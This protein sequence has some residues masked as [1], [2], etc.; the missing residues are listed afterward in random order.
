[1]S[2]EARNDEIE[3]LQKLENFVKFIDNDDPTIIDQFLIDLESTDS[4]LTSIIKENSNKLKKKCYKNELYNCYL[5]FV[6]G[7]NDNILLSLGKKYNFPRGLPIF[8]IPH[9]QINIYGFYPKFDN[10]ARN[11]K[12]LNDSEFEGN[13][14]NFNFKYSGFLGQIIAF[15]IEGKH[16]WTTCSKKATNTDFSNDLYRI[17]KDKMNSALVEK[18]CN[19]KIHFCGETMSKNDQVHG[20]R[21][22]TEAL[23]VTSVGKGKWYDLTHDTQKFKKKNLKKKL[24]K[25]LKNKLKNKLKKWNQNK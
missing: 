13:E 25:K 12:K 24:K 18:L 3:T 4:V 16:Y 14:L 7:D 1:M 23:I 19:E 5:I 2:E 6:N 8:Y 21:I 17:I 15:E 22:E 11:Q 9:K 10:D 20:S